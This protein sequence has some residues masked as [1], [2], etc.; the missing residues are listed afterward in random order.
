MLGS[1]NDFFIA[2]FN[3][4]I[5]LQSPFIPRV[6][7]CAALKLWRQGKCVGNELINKCLYIHMLTARHCF[8]YHECD[9]CGPVTGIRVAQTQGHIQVARGL[10]GPV[11]FFGLDHGTLGCA[12]ASLDADQPCILY[13]FVAYT[14]DFL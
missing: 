8:L 14:N 9:A 1:F 7:L 10:V 11:H 13:H 6:V 5:A 2:F 4:E 3:L 12:Y